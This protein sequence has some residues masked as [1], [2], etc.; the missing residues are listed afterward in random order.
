MDWPS[1]AP[2]ADRYGA[3]TLTIILDL[4]GLLFGLPQLGVASSI[5]AGIGVAGALATA[6]AGLADW[7]DDFRCCFGGI[8]LSNDRRLSGRGHGVP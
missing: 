6:A 5:T 7:M 1:I 2:N 8:S 4:V 3:W